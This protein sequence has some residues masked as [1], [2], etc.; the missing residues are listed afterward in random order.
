MSKTLQNLPAILMKN[1]Y[2]ALC[3]VLLS[4]LFTAETFAQQPDLLHP[5]NLEILGCSAPNNNVA[6]VGASQPGNVFFPGEEIV[7]S[8]NVA[9]GATGMYNV[10]VRE[11]TMRQNVYHTGSSSGGSTVFGGI[12]AIEVAEKME[13]FEIEFS[14]DGK[15]EILLPKDYAQRFG[16]YLVSVGK[17]DA[18]P[19]FLCTFVRA[20]DTGNK[21]SIDSPVFGEGQFITHDKQ[22]PV[23]L[24]QRMMTLRRLGIRGARIEFGWQ[25]RGPNDHIWDRYDSIMSIAEECGLKFLVTVSGHPSWTMPFGEPTPSALNEKPDHSCMPK[26]YDDFEQW[27]EEFCRRYWKDGNGALWSIEH[28]NEPWDGISISGWE[29]D[30]PHYRELMKRI[31]SGARKVDPRIKTAAACSSM[32][33]EDK[34]FT[35]DDR[36]K[37][38]RFIDLFTDHYVLP[39]NTYGPMVAKFWGK[40]NT[41]TETWIAATEMLLP[42]VMCQ[43]MG[44][45]QDR[46][47]PWHPAMTYFNLPN[48][49]M[50]FQ[51]PNPVGLS[52]NTFNFFCNGKPFRN[53][54]FL[55]HLPWAFQFG[56]DDDAVVVLLGR[57]H[58][59][60]Y[61]ATAPRDTL[62]WQWNCKE[63]G[64]MTLDNADGALEFYDIAGNR[65][66]AGEQTIHLP[67]DYLAH[68]ILA[69]QGGT[70]LIAE[71]L[72][73]A[74]FADVIPVEIIVRHFS[75]PVKNGV[76]FDL[77]LHN[78]LPGPVSGKLTVTPP[79]NFLIE[80]KQPIQ[81]S[82]G[83]TQTI[84]IRLTQAEPNLSNAYP[85][86]FRFESE[87]GI[88]EWKETVHVLTARKS[89]KTIDGT[90]DDWKDD[91]GIV[92]AAVKQ[93]TG[94]TEQMWLPFLEYKESH[95]DASFGEMKLAWDDHFLYIGAKVHSPTAK[96]ARMRLEGWDEDQ[97]FRSAADDA[98]CER[99]REYEKFLS[100]NRRNQE[101][102]RTF[103]DD[104]KWKEYLALLDS[105]PDLQAAVN[106]NAAKV[107]LAAKRRNPNVTFADA[108]HVYKQVPWNEQFWQGDTLQVAFD[109]IDGYG[110]HNLFVD[111]DRVPSG[112]HAMPDTDFEFGIYPCTDGS[113]EIWRGLAPGIPRGHYYPRQPRAAYDQGPVKDG[114]C[115]IK[116]SGTETIYEAAIPW[117][118]L[119]GWQPKVGADFGFMFRFTTRQGSPIV[120]GTD[121]SA[122]KSNGLTLHPYFETTPNCG[123]RW[124]FVQ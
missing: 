54:L 101:M 124:T 35:G 106:T 48:S 95:P 36:T 110:H 77:D 24:R 87:E 102:D 109:A 13:T 105:D 113:P 33:T 4:F 103:A 40:E 39:R 41:D 57:L 94:L 61:D 107:Y 45:G 81:L 70:A 65:E 114:Q 123:V 49:P 120:F 38:A 56:D 47:T 88:A 117:S 60:T 50:L 93:Q 104:P 58:P 76:H 96:T 15:T 16:T 64:T 85:F 72:K 34:F 22:D 43:F 122:T 89:T 31:A 19:V 7:L 42:Q 5:K 71:R 27:V 37:M 10:H 46:V 99:L 83:N 91:A 78:L 14:G 118:K 23:L 115:V 66:F 108:T 80:Y 44:S 30:I 6:F 63:G 100:V 121:K 90:L 68:Y 1:I 53:L 79:K 111:T 92:V 26:Y 32:N 21:G 62:W 67:V 82:G 11:I 98:I 74:V 3:G 28:W 52:S 2:I 73:T 9:S 51:L 20:H 69:P 8:V 17:K 116:S 112:F 97:Y 86:E 12:P 29:S 59:L 75:M 119:E 55:K 18:K 84:S 25:S